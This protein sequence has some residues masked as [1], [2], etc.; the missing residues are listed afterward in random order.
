MIART[1]ET[2]D[3]A[4]PGQTLGRY[5]LLAQLGQG[6]MGAIYLAL[7]SGSGD[8][9]KLVV[10]KEL[11]ADLA[12]NKEVVQ[13]F[14]HETKLA[15]RLSHSNIVQTL[16]ADQVD[17]RYFLVMEYL[18]GQPFSELQDRA[19]LAP[20][21]PLKMRLQV[22]C[23]VLSGLHY[24]HEL[25]D[26]HQQPTPIVHCDVSFSNVFVTYDGNVKVIDFGVA[27][28][29]GKLDQTAGFQGRVRYAAPEQ[30]LNEMI[31]RRADIFS[32]GVMLWEA[33]ALQRFSAPT[34]HDR[35]AIEQRLRG[36]EPSISTVV[37]NIDPRLAE[38]CT[39]AL[40]V[41]PKERFASAEE[42]RLAL[43]SYVS[44]LGPRMDS[45]EIG[46]FMKLK[47]SS[48]LK[49]MHNLV[50]EQL[51]RCD[52]SEVIPRA[53]KRNPGPDDVTTVADLSTFVIATRPTVPP[54]QSSVESLSSSP[55]LS[56]SRKA[57]MIGT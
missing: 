3:F 12:Q 43:V 54:P 17:G 25:R 47:F 1:L 4:T 18:D 24:A 2:T 28:A 57:A 44:T 41:D 11:R 22:I 40:K 6:G 51:L 23:E 31:D 46:S 15:G 49:K 55:Q 42:F 21:V 27:R 36:E 39:R 13:L 37:P 56:S 48:E 26:F 5:R 19:N 52:T 30:L 32:T 35:V 33:I 14:L 7:M 38:I 10:L 45:N 34:V 20:L 8:F 16:E 29:A 50:D 53:Q 9:E